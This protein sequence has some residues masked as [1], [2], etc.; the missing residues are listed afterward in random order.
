MR[1]RATIAALRIGLVLAAGSWAALSRGADPALG[2]WPE[3]PLKGGRVLH[4]AKVLSDEGANLVLRCDEGLVKVA[5][6]DLPPS[7]AAAYPQAP[8]APPGSQM[9]MRPFDPDKAPLVDD[10]Y[11]RPKPKAA[12]KPASAQSEMPIAAQS[13]VFKGCTIASFT[14][15]PF[16]NAQG[17]AEVV[18]QNDSEARAVIL[19]GDIVCVTSDGKHLVG[20]QIVVD[21]FPPVIKRRQVVPPLSSVTLQVAFSNDALEVSDVAWT[22]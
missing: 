9:V 21:G 11:D 17:C 12:A 15:K 5:K 10:P 18:V 19:P 7:V 4:G 6:S 8:D 13:P 2:P 1:F 14:M 16:L 3:L 20:R 22:R